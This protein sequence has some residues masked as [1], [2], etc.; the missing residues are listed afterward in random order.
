MNV[1]LHGHFIA[2]V[3]L[4]EGA[5]VANYPLD[6]YSDGSEDMRG[7]KQAAQDDETFVHLAQTYARL[8]KTMMQ[9]PV[10]SSLA[11]LYCHACF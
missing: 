8:H 1:T 10:R 7:Q 3:S 11:C 4:H 2:S 9:S 6:G 5:L